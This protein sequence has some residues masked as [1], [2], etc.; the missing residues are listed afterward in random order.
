MT[1][2]LEWKER[3]KQAAPGAP[4]DRLTLERVTVHKRE[5]RIVVRFQSGQIL[6][7]QEYASVKQGLAEMFGKRSGLAVDV[8][9]ACP[10]LADD[11]LADPEKYAAWLTDALCAQM[12]SAR[13]HLSGASWTVEKNTVTLTVRAKIA[14]DLLLL[15]RADEVIGKI[16]SQVFRRDA[17]VQIISREQERELESLLKHM[18]DQVKEKKKPEGPR[19]LYGRKI[20]GSTFDPIGD[21]NETSG[22]VCVEGF[23]LKKIESKELRGGSKTLVTFGVTDY[24]GSILC[25]VFLNA[26]QGE[27]KEIQGL[28]AGIRV[29]VRGACQW[30]SFSKEIALMADDVQQ[31]PWTPRRDEEEVKRV[32]LHLHTQMSNMDGVTSAAALI[33]RAAEWGH[34]A[35][36]ITDHGVVQAYPEAFDTVKKLKKEG[37]NIKLIPGMEGYLIDDSGVIVSSPDDGSIDRP[38]VVLDIETTGLYAGKDRIIEIAAVRIGPDDKIQDE[39]HTMVDPGMRIPPAT[40]AVHGITDDMVEGAPGIAEVMPKLADFCRGYVVCA[41]NASFDIGFLRI[42]AERAGVELPAAVLDT[43][44]LARAVVPELKRHKLDQVC[45]KL[46]VKLDNH[47][48]ALYDTRAT[49]HMLVRL[50]ERARQNHGVKTLRD[51]NDKLGER[52]AAAGTSYHIILLAKDRTGLENLYRLV[53]DAHLKHFDRRPH[54]LKSELK[55]RREGLIVGSACEAGELIRAMVEGKSER[56]IERIA[57]FYDYLEIQPTGNNA[58]MVRN[59]Q[60]ADEKGLQDLNRRV[61]RLGDKLGKP[62]CATCDVHFMDPEDAVFREILMTGMGFEDA[63]QQAP[64]YFRT[65]REMLDEFAYLGDRA[66][67]VVI[68]N[69]RRIADMV[70]EVKMFPK[71]PKDEET[72]QPQLPH[73]EEEIERMAWENARKI[74]GDPLPEIVSARLDRELKSILGHGFGTLYY[75]AHLLVKKSNEDGFLVGSRGSV[76]SSFAATMCNITEVN[77]LPPH[78]VCPHCQFSDFDV[79]VHTYPCGI[80]LPERKCPRC[81]ADLKHNGYDI[82]FE[83]FLGFNGDKVPDIDLNFSGIYQHRAHEYVRQLFGDGKVFKAGTIGTLA[84]KTAYGYVKKWCEETGHRATAMEMD[85]LV[86]G[87]VGV[88]R[89]TGQHPAGMVIVPEEYSIYQFSPIQHPADDKGSGIITTHFDFG[90]LHDILVKLDVLGHDD[91]TMIN[92][93]ERLTGIHAVDL[94]LN[95]KKVLGLFSSPEPLDL[96]PNQIR[97]VNTGTLGIPEFG[98]RF[99]RQMLEDTKPSTMAELIRISGLSH[100]TDVWLNNAQDLILQ[101]ICKLNDCFCTRDDIM[102]YLISM[103]VA[104]KM[105]FTTMESVRK[106]RGLTPEMEQAMR[107][108]NVPEYY[109]DSCKKIKYMFPKGHAAAYVMMALRVAW[110]K[111][112]RPLEYYTTFYT[113][114]ADNFDAILMLRD[115]EELDAEMKRIDKLGKHERTAKDDDTYTLLELVYEMRARGIEFLPVD[116]YK[117]SADEFLIQE[118]KIRPPFNRLPGV[119]G[120]AAETLYAACQEAVKENRPFIS[121]E[122]LK[123]RAAASSGTIEQLRLAGAL[124]GLPETSQVTLF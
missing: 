113:V 67:E 31:M 7:Q 64:L 59:G 58:F 52:V 14:A 28:K 20:T 92:M 124:R 79:D 23:V 61:L 121:V 90:S 2:V 87:C 57:A 91:P 29:R 8:F 81:G 122:D 39:F 47:H 25:K 104:P 112:Y 46:D 48:R 60:I 42:D 54:I 10:T 84:D 93:L 38:Y 85:R 44:P 55:A 1:A 11:F 108:N 45:K 111:V 82:P 115:P 98:T 69:P 65:T 34:E 76:G 100:G 18:G 119:G 9:V 102:N 99:V 30:D 56:E 97:G 51:L 72:F 53:S 95:D 86:Q 120:A 49:A 83:V 89:T 74:Y 66:R 3:L 77:P 27:G 41:H 118:G 37:K 106:G 22:R 32:E 13:P 50:L 94:P 114:R 43:L 71:H 16:L 36:A 109:V 110:F 4:V 101:G 63:S 35:I 107:E 40:I 68:D 24:T 21:L 123:A 5:G 103:G 19:V 33:K 96:A 17:A 105:A 80:D 88:K 70:G 73:A 26:E 116:L 62:V 15:R 75:S 6:T 117:S 12:P 78:Y